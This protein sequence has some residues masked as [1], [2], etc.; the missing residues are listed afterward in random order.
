M[1]NIEPVPAATVVLVRESKRQDDLEILLLLR[2]SKL[3]F[4]GGHWV[5][6]GGR[7]DPSDFQDGADGLEYP[8]AQRAAV[9][10]TSEE[11]GIDILES[12]LVHT[13]HWTTPPNMP[14][15]FSTWFFVCLITEPVM[16]N[17]DNQEILD[18]RWVSP[19]AALAEADSDLFVLPRPTMVTLQDIAPYKSISALNE[20]LNRGDIR[21]F[22]D[23]SPYY[24]PSEMGC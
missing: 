7:V 19:S 21:V 9:R 17:V 16:V 24:R 23:D 6:P 22:P 11:A 5:F 13:A 2:N 12:Q 4:H 1:P 10:E 14:R 15:R 3:A 18:H 20:Y 8:A